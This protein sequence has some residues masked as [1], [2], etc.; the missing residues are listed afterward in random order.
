MLGTINL[1]VP[2]AIINERRKNW[3]CPPPKVGSGLLDI[4]A[5]NCR[6]ADEG[7]AMQPWNIDFK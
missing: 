2:E 3:V 4:Y 7:G 5:R 1:E 6:T